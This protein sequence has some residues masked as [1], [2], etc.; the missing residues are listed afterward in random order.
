MP[1]R[2]QVEIRVN[3]ISELAGNVTA[4]VSIIAYGYTA[5]T[6]QLNPC[7]VS[8]FKGMCP[9]TKG[10]IVLNSK[11]DVPDSVASKIPGIFWL[12]F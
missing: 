1:D 9:M 2:K 4:A 6:Q 11:I 12:V 8:G 5:I 3:G 10:V 7:G